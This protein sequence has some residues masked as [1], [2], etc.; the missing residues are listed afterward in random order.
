MAPGHSSQGRH[1]ARACS[2][3]RGHQAGT[4]DAVVNSP[5]DLRSLDEEGARSLV[6]SLVVQLAQVVA[7]AALAAKRARGMA[8]FIEGLLTLFPGLESHLTQDD[9]D[10][11]AAYRVGR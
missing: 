10:L 11:L 7:E 3:A 6:A 8:K 9:R 4:A 5:L 2:A 1:L